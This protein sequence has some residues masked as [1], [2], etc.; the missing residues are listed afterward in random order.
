[1][2]KFKEGRQPHSLQG[3]CSTSYRTY[4]LPTG[5]KKPGNPTVYMSS[6]T[7]MLHQNPT[8]YRP[9]TSDLAHNLGST[10]TRRGPESRKPRV[11]PP[12]LPPSQSTNWLTVSSH[13]CL[14]LVNPTI[15]DV[16]KKG[17]EGNAPL[18]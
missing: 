10:I 8:G 13:G 1:M 15:P 12:V 11:P 17:T 2:Q 16:L 6:K 18:T 7:S 4:K 9:H 14:T 5:D 3:I